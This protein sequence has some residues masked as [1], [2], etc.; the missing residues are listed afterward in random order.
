MTEDMQVRNLAKHA[1]VLRATGLTVCA[2]FQ[3]IA[4]AVGSGGHPHLPGF[5]N[6]RKETGAQFRAHHGF[7]A[8]LSL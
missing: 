7:G 6:Q 5:L 1:N 8:A 2:P 4:R 3:Q